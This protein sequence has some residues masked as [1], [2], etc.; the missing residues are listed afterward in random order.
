MDWEFTK[1]G[2]SVLVELG[3]SL[4]VSVEFSGSRCREATA[5]R[6]AVRLIVVEIPTK[7]HLRE[8]SCREELSAF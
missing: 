1:P 4:I 2:F 8:H 3:F 7:T 6:T 5:S